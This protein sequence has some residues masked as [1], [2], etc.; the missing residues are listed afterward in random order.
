M[1][2]RPRILPTKQNHNISRESNMHENTQ[3]SSQ[4]QW[5]R[6][7]KEKES[8]AGHQQPPD[9]VTSC[10]PPEK[11][12]DPS[13]LRRYLG[14]PHKVPAARFAHHKATLPPPP[15]YSIR[16]KISSSPAATP[17]PRLARPNK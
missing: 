15:R 14:L 17:A 13:S 3:K 1:R 4:R 16:L 10:C 5:T 6:E 11:D 12:L 8:R 2:I 7:L 9:W